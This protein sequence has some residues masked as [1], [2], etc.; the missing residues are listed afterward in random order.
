M[1]RTDQLILETVT[2]PAALD[3]IQSNLESLWAAH[4]EVPERVRTRVALAVA[5]VGANIVEHAGRGAPVPMRME[6]VVV[7]NVVRVT[8]TDQGGEVSV[9]LGA[10]A[11]PVGLAERGRGLAIAQSV[12]GEL[13][14][15]R[16]GTVNEWTLVSEDFA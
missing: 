8:F 9:D 4:S 14:Y 15:R 11:M 6:S 2:G 16:R 1:V 3:D 13:A 5:E 7:G 10:V 12:L